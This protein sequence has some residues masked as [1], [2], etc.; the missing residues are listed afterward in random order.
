[1]N[2]LTTLVYGTF[3]HK[4]PSDLD[5]NQFSS[6]LTGFIDAEGNF[7][8]LTPEMSH[9]HLSQAFSSLVSVR[10]VWVYDNGKLLNS[11]PF[12]SYADASEAIG[13]PRNSVAVR[14]NIDTGKANLSRYTFYSYLTPL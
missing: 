6:W 14:R 11:Q 9:L 5:R 2:I 7:Q 12:T 1:M 13:I 4:L 3:N 10:M 8:V